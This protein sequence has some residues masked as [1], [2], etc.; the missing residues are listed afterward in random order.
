MGNYVFNGTAQFCLGGGLAGRGVIQPG[1]YKLNHPDVPYVYISPFCL[2]QW[3]RGRIHVLRRDGPP[4]SLCTA[5]RSEIDLCPPG[6]TCGVLST[7]GH[8]H[9]EL[10]ALPLARMQSFHSLMGHPFLLGNAWS[11]GTSSIHIV[12]VRVSIRNRY[13][14]WPSSSIGHNF[15]RIVWFRNVLVCLNTDTGTVFF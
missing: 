2:A 11:K 1:E 8:S 6:P 3:S 5:L 4:L 14:E 15:Q 10:L 13:P 7:G 9:T 12:L